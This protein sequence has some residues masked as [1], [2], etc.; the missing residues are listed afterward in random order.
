MGCDMTGFPCVYLSDQQ[1]TIQFVLRIRFSNQVTDLSPYPAMQF[2]YNIG[3][4]QVVGYTAPANNADIVPTILEDGTPAH[5]VAFPITVSVNDLCAVSNSFPYD[6]LYQFVDGGTLDAYPLSS[7]PGLFPPSI[8][9]VPQFEYQPA[10][11]TKNVCC[12]TYT[13]DCGDPT[14]QF[15]FGQNTGDSKNEASLDMALGAGNDSSNERFVAY[16]NPFENTIQ[17]DY[18]LENA[19]EINLICLDA[20]GKNMAQQVIRHDSEGDYNWT[21]STEDWPAGM[22]FVRLLKGHE[23]QTLKVM[24]LSY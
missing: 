19:G 13:F 14:F 3:N 18:K 2:Y 5:E 22:Y 16:P 6:I 24:K 11:L 10:L 21:F 9:Y 15:G 1:N 7:Y 8:F 12:F 4:G 20:N 23:V 17:L